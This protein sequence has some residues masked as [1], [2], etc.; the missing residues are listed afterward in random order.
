MWL[1]GAIGV[2]SGLGRALTVWAASPCSSQ[3]VEMLLLAWP[4]FWLLDHPVLM[5]AMLGQMSFAVLM[6]LTSA[7]MK[8]HRRKTD[9]RSS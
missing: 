2:D 8:E 1:A 5:I 6:G 9:A 4:F 3:R 7:L